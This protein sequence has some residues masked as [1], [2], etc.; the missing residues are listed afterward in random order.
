MKRIGLL[1]LF[2]AAGLYGHAQFEIR[3]LAGFNF[4]SV[5]ESP[6]VVTTSAKVG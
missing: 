5:Q 1:V 2:I 3:P 6:G 4:R